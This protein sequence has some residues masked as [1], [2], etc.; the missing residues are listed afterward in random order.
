MGLSGKR[1]NQVNG[2]E[3]EMKVITF[4]YLQKHPNLII[5]AGL[6]GGLLVG[7]TARAWM[8]WISTKPEFSWPGTLSIVIGFGIFG[9]IQSTVYTVRSKRRRKWLLVLIRILGTIFTLPLF[10]AAGGMMLPTVLTVSLAVWREKWKI[11][12]RVLLSL[13]GFTI[14]VL[15]INSQIVDKFGWSIATVGRILLFVMIYSTVIFALKP[16]ISTRV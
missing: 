6:V 4:S 7:V 14:W 2:G 13:F 16:T 9:A 10:V 8:R 5:P 1:F 12:I 15:I 11:W 3:R